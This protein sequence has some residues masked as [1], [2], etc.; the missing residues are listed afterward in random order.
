ML[1]SLAWPSQCGAAQA[2]MAMPGGPPAHL[3]PKLRAFMDD[4]RS[5]VTW[6]N[7]LQIAE[8]FINDR[9]RNLSQ[10]AVAAAVEALD[11]A[12]LSRLGYRSGKD[13][14]LK[15]NKISAFRAA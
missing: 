5:E 3:L 11:Y 1:D 8:L 10:Q 4:M 12:D 7:R 13:C 14:L 9:D 15:S 2:L 6:P